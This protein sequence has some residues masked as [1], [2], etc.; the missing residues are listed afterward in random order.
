MI[1]DVIT[2]NTLCCME[3]GG[4]ACTIDE[5]SWPN[6]SYSDMNRCL[7]GKRINKGGQHTIAV[8][9][10]SR[11]MYPWTPRHKQF[12]KE[13]KFTQEGPME[14]KCLCKM[15][16]PLVKGQP[17]EEN[18]ERRPIFDAKSLMNTLGRMVTRP[19]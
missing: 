18:N 16:T 14:L 5:T 1:W 19:S 11:Y 4:L 2:H 8:D 9:A 13:G 12:K 10:K 15:L 3:K 7:K 6:G 17:Q